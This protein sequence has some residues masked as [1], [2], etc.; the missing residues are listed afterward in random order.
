MFEFLIPAAASLIGGAM[1]SRQIGKAQAAEREQQDKALQLQRQMYEEGIARQQPFLQTGTEFFNQ[2]AALQRGG[3]GAAQNVLQMDPG[4]GFR[5]GEGLKALERS[6]A[7]RGGLL[8]GNMLRGA[9]RYGQDLASQEFGAAYNRL[10]G[11]AGVG[12]SAA[13]V[14]NTLGQNYAG[15]AG[16]IY[17]AMGQTAG[18]AALARGSVYGNVLNQLG[19]I[20][21]RYFTPSGTPATGGF[22]SGMLPGGVG[23]PG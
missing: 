8:S 16:N 15:G 6:A 19:G 5:L 3:P 18:Q 7:A 20:G 1:Q 2:L 13:G 14:M 12:P 10:A 22:P 23:F 4:Y 17:G 9:Q 11:L 21:G